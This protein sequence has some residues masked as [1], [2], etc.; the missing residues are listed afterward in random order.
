MVKQLGRLY[1]R[2]TMY[3]KLYKTLKKKG[4]ACLLLLVNQNIHTVVSL[5]CSQPCCS[6]VFGL[7]L[8]APIS[9]WKDMPFGA[10]ILFF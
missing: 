10:S 2:E 8:N 4:R 7:I 3:T 9:Q 5:P 6:I 1:G